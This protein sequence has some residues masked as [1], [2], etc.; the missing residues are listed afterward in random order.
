M[1]HPRGFK[2]G[3]YLYIFYIS[4]EQ[5]FKDGTKKQNSSFNG[6]YAARSRLDS[7][8]GPGTWLCGKKFDTSCLPKEIKSWSTL[9]DFVN[10]LSLKGPRVKPIIAGGGSM[11][12]AVARV[13]GKKDLFVG[14]SAMN[15]DGKGWASIRVSK[16][17][18]NWSD[19]KKIPKT[20]YN[21]QSPK[22]GESDV[23][24]TWASGDF[25]FPRFASIEKG[26]PEEINP[27]KFFIIGDSGVTS[28]GKK[29]EWQC[30]IS[31]LKLS[32]DVQ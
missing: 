5:V 19:P 11:S 16:D 14:I 2:H 30:R 7:G 20:E 9:D 8:L 27:N 25:I 3:K 21:I 17:L 28:E 18:V 10:A 23:A 4:H 12:F 29:C 31:R 32:I 22:P 15:V 1:R 24:Q 13:K 6:I 26:D